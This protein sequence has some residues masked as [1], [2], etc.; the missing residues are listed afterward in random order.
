MSTRINIVVNGN[1]HRVEDKS[2]LDEFLHE[3]LK[4]AKGVAV[5]MNQQVIPKSQWS[6]CILKDNDELV[7]IKAVQ[8]G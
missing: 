8:G 3:F 1:K 2:Y 7:I 5:A 6:E 4:E